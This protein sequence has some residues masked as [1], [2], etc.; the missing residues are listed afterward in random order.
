M[1]DFL[2]QL[3]SF[4][5]LFA[6]IINLA[7]A[8]FI[9]LKNC[10]SAMNRSFFALLLGIALWTFSLFLFL[11][12]KDTNWVLFIRRL[13]PIGSS[14]IAGYFLYFS[15]LFPD[16]NQ[17]LS[18]L[19]KSLILLPGY[20]FS[21][22]T[23]L[24]PFM[25][26]SISIQDPSYPF[27]G[28]PKFGF[29]YKLFAV[30]FITYFIASISVL[31]YKYLKSE[32]RVK[33]QLWYVLFGMAL[34]G[35]AGI[36][37]SLIM[38]ILNMSQFFTMGPIFTLILAGFISYAIVKHKLLQIEELLTRGI[39]LLLVLS[40]IVGTCTFILIEQ[41]VFIPIFYLI[42]IQVGLGAVIYFQN[43]KSEINQ[44]YSAFVL[45]FALWNF[46]S[47]K[48]TQ[49]SSFQMIIEDKLIFI[50]AAFLI[51][52]FLYFTYVFPRTRKSFNNLRRG[53]IFIPPAIMAALVPFDLIVK[54]VEVINGVLSPVF[55]K[56][57]LLFVG[58]AFVYIFI[59]LNN[60]VKQYVA[61]SGIEKL[62]V[63]YVFLGIFLSFFVLI[64]TNLILPWFGEARLT[65]YGS[66]FT[67]FFTCFTGY[68]IV[69][70][71]LMSIEFI[72]QRSS[73]YAFATALIM[74]LYVAAIFI[75]EVYLRKFIGYSSFLVTALSVLLIA[76]IYHPLVKSFQDVTDKIFFRNRY[77]YQK[78]LR[79]I[80]QQI[81]SVIKLDELTRLI[82]S[83]FIDTMK[84][85][86]ISFLLPDKEHFRSTPLVFPRYKKIEIDIKSPIIN[87]LSGR[88]DILIKEEIEEEISKSFLDKEELI[89]KKQCEEL[90][91]AIE[92]LGIP[93]WVPIILKDKLIGIIALGDKLSGEVFTSED[94]ELLITLAN[95]TALALDNSR[96][97]EEVVNI[98]DYNEEVLHSM[99]S[100][101]ITVDTR[102]NIVTFNPM[103]EK[104]TGKNAPEII[105]KNCKEIWGERGTI[106]SVIENTL[107]KE[108]GYKNYESG[109]IVKDRGM[110]PVSLS[111][112]VIHDHSRKKAG[113]LVNIMDLTE[114][115]EL[116]EKVRRADKLSALATMAAGMA[117]EI[118]NP[119]SSMKVL[120]QLL[121]IRFQDE[122][123]R[124][125][126]IEILP[127]EIARIDRI[128]ESLLG[129][130]RAT[131]PKYEKMR[132]ESV[133]EENIV[134]YT[135]QA[136]TSGV[137]ISKEFAAL[138]EIMG[139]HD[140]LNQVFSNLMLNAIQAMPDGG[141]LE[142]KTFEGKK[143]DDVL[144]SIKIEISDTGHGIPPQNL[145][146]LFDPF[147]TTKYS[148]TGL[149]LTITHNIIEGHRGQ[150]D[151]QSEL[152]KGT[153]FTIALPIN[154]EL[155]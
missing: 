79:Q 29:L 3:Q 64:L 89:L 17:T 91:D 86:E 95:Q 137:E 36:I 100:G 78:V 83:S 26:E 88:R 72:I 106:T 51:A 33:L 102:G 69:K 28:I 65:P 149:G 30:Y 22:L 113:A 140:Q 52:F 132:I 63:K 151:V 155:V 48:V 35:T 67:L 16:Q 128:V 147:F 127:R 7:L 46:F 70:H 114:V 107:K 153:T 9:L 12:I 45:F 124:K 96:L 15:L 56:C 34:A 99:V 120:S 133:I 108:K 94:I 66:F 135:G 10:H 97:Y 87:W 84:V 47:F 39:Y 8:I 143:V 109:I 130:A 62:Q 21:L 116:E 103:A 60:L 118:K 58:Y 121:P 40:A 139:D 50:P 110:V 85:S 11:V 14:L 138:P 141:K 122:E 76:F 41:A 44:A 37:F 31:V 13:T 74:S 90:R 1:L 98:K 73:V 71:R 117:H 119:L 81:S 148:G 136:K 152:E 134:Y 154:Q 80:S 111:S 4:F 49:R 93:V 145:K 112:I 61:S 2:I 18:T 125:K 101:V 54:N 42:L 25:V 144:Q 32:G 20:L 92:R 115:K 38:P 129:F 131:S 104:I 55:G 126:C 75:S 59:G 43:R 123:F 24:T 19:K 82:A 23:I 6:F 146:K 27:L 57:Y 150:I 5:L 142:I 53:L 77:N 68:A 105:G